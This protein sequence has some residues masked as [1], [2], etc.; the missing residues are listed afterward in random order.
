MLIDARGLK[1][2][3]PLH[4]LREI[5]P[6]TCSIDGYVEL[7]VDDEKALRQL[8]TYA[9]ISGCEYEILNLNTHYSIRI[10]STCL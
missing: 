4:K 1:F 5:S 7:L 10:K 9:A 2:P 8:K 6:T 3:E